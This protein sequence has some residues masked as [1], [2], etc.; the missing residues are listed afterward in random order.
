MIFIAYAFHFI[1]AYVFPL[2]MSF[3]FMM[4]KGEKKYVISLFVSL[5]PFETLMY[6]FTLI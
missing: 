6:C 4:T 3:F 1:T 2:L 5:Y